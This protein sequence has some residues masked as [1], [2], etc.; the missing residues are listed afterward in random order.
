MNA[1]KWIFAA[2]AGFIVLM[3]CFFI[4]HSMQGSEEIPKKYYE[5]GNAFQKD[6]DARQ[7]AETQNYKPKILWNKNILGIRFSDSLCPDSVRI[8][9][10]LETKPAEAK[11]YRFK[12][13]C[14]I[15]ISRDVT[16]T[17]GFL[18]LQC[19]YYK[20]GKRYQITDKFFVN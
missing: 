15:N 10:A 12:T 5:K 17:T 20:A 13:E 9:A 7:L 18:K 2:L 3:I 16:W 8:E 4:W 6:L 1:G 11:F 19:D 14:N